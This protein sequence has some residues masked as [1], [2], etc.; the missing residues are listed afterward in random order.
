MAAGIAVD[1]FVEDMKGA[2]LGALGLLHG[3]MRVPHQ[4]VGAGLGAGMGDAQAA[5]DQQALAIDPI[6]LG[7]G[8]G[9]ALGHPFGAL[10]RAAGVD[11]QGKLIAAQARQLVAGFELAL[12]PRNHLQDQPVAGLVAEGI[13][14]V[15]EVVEVQVAQ[16]QAAPFVFRQARGQQGLEALAV[17]DTGQRVLLG[18]ALQGV[19]QHATLAHMAQAAAQGIGVQW[20]DGSAS[21]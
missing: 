5:T 11:Q 19:F 2:A 1:A 14:G 6:G 18:Q 20:H 4:R 9:D 16:G 15:T 17:G 13:V 10:G 21:H 7:H 8:F 12:E 3:D